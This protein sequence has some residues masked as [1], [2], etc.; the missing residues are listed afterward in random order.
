M[1]R[2]S[3]SYRHVSPS[4]EFN[5]AMCTILYKQQVSSRAPYIPADGLV[6]QRRR[7]H[8]AATMNYLSSHGY[9]LNGDKERDIRRDRARPMR[10]EFS[11]P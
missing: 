4:A 11:L 1:C 6:Q 5:P 3:N 8:I 10:D 9:Y 7:G 2:R